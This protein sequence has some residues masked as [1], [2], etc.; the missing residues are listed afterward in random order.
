MIMQISNVKSVNAA[1]VRP[2]GL[3][4]PHFAIDALDVILRKKMLYKFGHVER[5]Q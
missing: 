4:A 5:S 1:T 3:L 2:N